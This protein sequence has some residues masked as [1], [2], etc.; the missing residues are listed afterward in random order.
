MLINQIHRV[1][2]AFYAGEEPFEIMIQMQNPVRSDDETQP[3][4]ILCVVADITNLDD[5]QF[6]PKIIDFNPKLSK[7][8]LLGLTSGPGKNYSL[9][10]SPSWKGKPK[11]KS[12]RKIK[13]IS[14]AK[15]NKQTIF[16]IL[17]EEFGKWATKLKRLLE[18]IKEEEKTLSKTISSCLKSEGYTK[19]NN[20]LIF[21]I[22][23]KDGEKFLGEIPIMCR[24]YEYLFLEEM[25]SEY[26]GAQCKTCGETKGLREGFNL[27]LFTLD[28]LSFKSAF[29]DSTTDFSC[30][31]LMCTDCYLY[32]LLGFII[33]KNRLQF[34]AYKIKEGQESIPI[35]HYIIPTVR[36]L[37][38]L[39]EQVEIL[40]RAKKEYVDKE[41]KNIVDNINSINEK[42]SNIKTKDKKRTPKQL[43]SI[44]K[45][46]E[47]DKKKQEDQLKYVS[48][49]NKFRIEDLVITLYQENNLI[50]LLDIYFKITNQKLNPK[51][52]QIVSQINLTSKQIEFLAKVF[53][54][55]IGKLE[56][57][58]IQLSSLKDLLPT[59]KFLHYY[60]SLLSLKPIER[61]Q[62][63][64]D[65][66]NILKSL[67]ITYINAK[68]SQNKKEKSYWNSL[69]SYELYDTLI[70]EA[71]L[72]R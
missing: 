9:T 16:Q 43:E 17:S 49:S 1:G 14:K 26:N 69:R 8:Y 20:P 18:S 3:P 57:N 29:F 71:N 21:K 58:T 40:T 65:C 28:Q 72:W 44:R 5:I 64:H 36:D 7:K 31:H 62:F 63:Q 32:T 41:R 33:I 38:I 55:T 30:Q 46:L 47:K 67:F 37:N 13:L 10:L 11:D 4:K 24:L 34:Y 51:T 50:P 59:R 25:D 66:A 68:N 6:E 56:G 15:I 61:V 42:I 39:K 70:S 45:E 53:K 12:F 2:Q 35:Y 54:N 60:S 48:S 22:K 19:F 52:K 23:D 27:G